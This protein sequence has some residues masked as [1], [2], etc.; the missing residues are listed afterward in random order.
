MCSILLLRRFLFLFFPIRVETL[1]VQKCAPPLLL[2]VDECLRGW[3]WPCRRVSESAERTDE[4]E[5]SMVVV[6]RNGG[7]G[8]SGGHSVDKADFELVAALIRRAYPMHD[9]L[10]P[11]S[12]GAPGAAASSKRYQY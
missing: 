2:I 11:A 12:D 7:G 3:W 4:Y 5:A 9:I 8:D 1:C 10:T 6:I